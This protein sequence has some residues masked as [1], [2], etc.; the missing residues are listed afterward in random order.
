VC[1]QAWV[2]LLSHDIASGA[3]WDEL[4]DTAAHAAAAVDLAHQGGPEFVRLLM[5]QA[6]IKR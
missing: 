5:H 4:D 2:D 6:R 3:A 1:P